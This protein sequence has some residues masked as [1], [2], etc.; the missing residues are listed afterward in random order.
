MSARSPGDDED[1]VGDAV[2][3]DDGDVSAR[4]VIPTAQASAKS[5]V[6]FI[7]SSLFSFRRTNAQ[8]FEGKAISRTVM[9][10]LRGAPGDLG[11]AGKY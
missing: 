2:A 5:R 4:P 11:P 6:L 3:A 1:G 9:G 10:R 8:E 7:S